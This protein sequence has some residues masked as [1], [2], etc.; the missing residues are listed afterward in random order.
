MVDIILDWN[1]ITIFI[2]MG[3]HTNYFEFIFANV[4]A[5][6]NRGLMKS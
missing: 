2:G 4:N 5:G 3:Y 6:A 1:K